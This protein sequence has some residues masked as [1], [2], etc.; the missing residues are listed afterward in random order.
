MRRQFKTVAAFVAVALLAA[1][2]RGLS[3]TVT[4]TLTGTIT[5]SSGAAIPDASVILTNQLSGDIRKTV[6][7]AAGYYSIPAIP[8]ATYGLTVEA[9]GFQ[10][11]QLAGI[12]LN[13]ADQ[14]NVN[15]TLQVGSVSETVEVSAAAGQLEVINSGEKAQVLDTQ[16]L[17]NIAVV[18]RSAA[19]FLKIMPGVAPATGVT[20]APGF[21]GEVIGINGSGNAGRQS[22]IGAFTAN[23]TPT[24]STEI[25]S[26]GA[27]TSD[28]GCNC[29]TP[30]NPNPEMLQEV[31]VLQA[32]FSA[33]NS[34]GPVVINT[35]T[36]AGGSQFHGELYD[37]I[38]NYNLNANDSSNNAKGLRA[39]GT[40]VAGRPQNVFN[41][42]GGNIGGPVLIPGTR[43]N[44]NRDKLFFF[45]GFEYFLQHLNT[46]TITAVVPTAAMR[47]G[48]FSQASINA[49]NPAA[50][51]GGGMKPVNAAQFPNGMIPQA[52]FDRGGQALLN[53]LPQPNADPFVTGGY[54]YVQQAPF[55]QNGWQT[56][57][58]L[59]YSISDN[60]KLFVR[61][62]HQQEVQNFP[63]SLWGGAS[64]PTGVPWPSNVAGNNHSESVSANLTRVF[65]PS[66]TNELVVAYTWIGFPN[67]LTN[68]SAGEKSTVGY[69]YHGVFNNGDPY[70]PDIIATGLVNMA[71][72]GGFDIAHAQYNGVYFANKPLASIGDNVVKIWR[73]HTFRIGTYSEYYG[74]IQPTQQKAQGVITTAANDP[75]GSGNAL[76]DLLLGNVSTF[77]QAN[78]NPNQ[79][80]RSILIEGYLQDSWKVMRR[81]TLDI[82]V[83]FQHDPQGLDMNGIGHAIF[84][85]SLW[86]N[87]PNVYLPGF[88]WTARDPSV[89]SEGYPTRA[90][91]YAPRFGEA[92]DLFGNGKTVIR[93]G[94]GLYRYRGPSGGGGAPVGLTQPVGQVIYS[95]PTSRGTTLTQL[96]QFTVPFQN[97]QNVSQLGLPD[98]LSSQ[99][100]MVW[101]DNFGITQKLP[102]DSDFE[103]AY[104]N[105]MG[106][107]IAE[108]VF[109]NLN[110]VP[111][112]AM[113]A[114]PNASNLLFRRYPNYQDITIQA[115]DA[116]SDYNAFQATFRHRSSRY[117]I[118]ANYTYA[119]VTGN[120][121]AANPNGGAST[122]LGAMNASGVNIGDGL[123]PQND[124]GPLSFD[125]RHVF[126]A[127][128][129]VNL[130]GLST[131]NRFVKGA[132]NGWTV[133]GILQLQSGAN[134]QNGTEFG[135]VMPAGTTTQIGITGTPDVAVAPVLTCDPRQN[136]GPRQYLNPNCFALPTPGHNGT[137]VIPEAFGPHFFNLDTSLFKTFHFSEKK[138]LQFRVEG[139]NFLNHANY[140]F[141]LDNNLNL[142]FNSAGR[143]TNALFG[144]T[145]TKTGHRILQFVGKFYF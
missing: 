10:K 103:A 115:F 22:A 65:S 79:R 64:A 41:F 121:A 7:N 23:G 105:T 86:S 120:T 90:L 109:N 134:L 44:K 27:H 98:N 104:V 140:S 31:H 87:N 131:A 89:P 69:P 114:T 13:S 56:V 123:N 57:H 39:D 96:D 88:T 14:R 110:P 144:S 45:S 127:A 74:N 93:G 81:L 43:F 95:P 6:S 136:L 111:Y 5:D 70:I 75:T 29:A 126:N 32:A 2:P 113:L 85:P 53:L 58:R 101:T 60:T 142:A 84:V 38:R 80:V 21:T 82:G 97:G 137:F 108:S 28:P 16:T 61:Y 118:S 135:M 54:N 76:A 112:G 8:A 9:N 99:L 141:G 116:Y 20:N 119:K 102:W 139:F 37:S 107:H 143:E 3:Q 124:H 59:D 19:E 125:R 92:L 42:P 15:V 1:A 72:Q 138:S 26:D 40:P 129:S 100:S 83:R 17:Q 77:S 117:L 25:T 67:T 62:Y 47:A 68:P 24:A 30:V 48:D 52:M 128:Y 145:T 36:K 18:G 33:E 73:T 34:Y 133:S 51:V 4:A 106:R 91:F 122:G 66:L 35:T 78:F 132:I 130:P 94:V 63:I 50:G 55:T 11:A 12:I 71:Q 49:L 46:A